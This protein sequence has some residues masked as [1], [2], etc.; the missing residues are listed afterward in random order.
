MEE[1]R[2]QLMALEPTVCREGRFQWERKQTSGEL[3]IQTEVRGNDVEL[4][5]THIYRQDDG[6]PF[7]RHQHVCRGV[8]RYHPSVVTVNK[9]FINAMA[10]A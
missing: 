3:T 5:R 9:C 7:L 1:F 2:E 10:Q 4:Y 6:E 8:I